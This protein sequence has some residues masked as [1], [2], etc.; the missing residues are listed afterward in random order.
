MEFKAKGLETLH[1]CT[2]SYWLKWEGRH[3]SVE[4]NLSRSCANPKSSR[5]ADSEAGP[6]RRGDDWDQTPTARRVNSPRYTHERI[7]QSVYRSICVVI[8]AARSYLHYALAAAAS[9]A[10]SENIALAAPH[11]TAHRGWY[12]LVSNM[13]LLWNCLGAISKAREHLHDTRD[14]ASF[15]VVT[16]SRSKL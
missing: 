10:R 11:R 13:V 8:Y 9:S 14:Y 12:S 1:S 6:E 5:E 4:S 15:G 2:E 16:R 7:L 3:V